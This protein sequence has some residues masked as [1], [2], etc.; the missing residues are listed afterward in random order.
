M[1][2]FE[3][4]ILHGLSLDHLNK[5]GE[6]GWELASVEH[7]PSTAKWDTFYLKREIQ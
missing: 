2:K 1:K 4:K 6:K 5:L 7:S 3:Y